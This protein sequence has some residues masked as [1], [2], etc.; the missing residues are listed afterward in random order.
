MT[1]KGWRSRKENI[2]ISRNTIHALVLFAICAINKMYFV[3]AN[4]HKDRCIWATLEIIPSQTFGENKNDVL[5][6]WLFLG[7]FFFIQFLI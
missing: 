1:D 4:N 5:H 6:N 2:I 3:N 7:I